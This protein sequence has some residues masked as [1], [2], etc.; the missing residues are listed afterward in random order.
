MDLMAPGT[1]PG[2]FDAV[3]GSAQRQHALSE[4]G[5]VEPTWFA[6]LTDPSTTKGIED[7]WDQAYLAA[8][9][10]EDD[11][12]YRKM[13]M[14]YTPSGAKR[15]YRR[16]YR[17]DGWTFRM[18]SVTACRRFS[19]EH[20]GT[21]ELPVNVENEQGQKVTGWVR[22]TDGG[23]VWATESLNMSGPNAARVEAVVQAALEA[24]RVT[25]IPQDE[26]GVDFRARARRAAEGVDLTSPVRSTWIANADYD[27]DSGSMAVRTSAGRVYGWSVS[28]QQFQSMVTSTSPGR[29]LNDIKR[30]THSFPVAEC[31]TCRRVHR[32]DG[33][34]VCR[35]R[36][37][38]PST[39]PVA[40]NE[41]MRRATRATIERALAA[42]DRL[43]RRREDAASRT[44]A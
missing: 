15:T 28:R 20:G 31:P 13:P 17:V 30:Q 44:T 21:F 1:N 37:F 9:A 33:E 4:Y 32:S 39:R 7:W 40:Q 23:G 27:D 6:A 5:M 2:Y 41:K 36:R 18:P 11:T 38:A 8:G 14:D 3:Y 16:S 26:N 22:V 24:K 42:R 34:H 12:G 29:I 25:R 35:T 43:A 19:S 10:R